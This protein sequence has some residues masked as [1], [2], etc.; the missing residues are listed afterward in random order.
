MSKLGK[1]LIEGMQEAV[2]HAK[3]EA[4][5]VKVRVVDPQGPGK[6]HVRG[7]Q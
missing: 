3:G 7:D 2:A 1:E 5:G 6:A 4:T